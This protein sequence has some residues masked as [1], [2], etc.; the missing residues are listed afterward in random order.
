[1]CFADKNP[2]FLDNAVAQCGWQGR[3]RPTVSWKA[4][5]EY[6][7]GDFPFKNGGVNQQMMIKHEDL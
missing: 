2:H 7:A 1:V 6:H 5:Q 3:E 4:P